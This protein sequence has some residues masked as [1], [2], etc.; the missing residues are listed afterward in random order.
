M[1]EVIKMALYYR[2]RRRKI[3]F[4]IVVPLLILITFLYI[5]LQISPAFI[6]LSED[7]IYSLTFNIINEVIGNELEKIDTT[8]LVDYK[9]DSAGKIVA[10]NA[11]ISIMNKLNNSISQETSKKLDEIETVLVEIPL[12]SFISNSFFSGIGPQLP[13]HIILLNNVTTEY[14]TEFSSTGIN[15]TRHR[16]FITVTC[17]VGALSTLAQNEQDIKVQIP[18][19]ETIIVGNVPTTY[20]DFDNQ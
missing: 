16:I 17:N 20:F 8:S 10:V 15:Q 5:F 4:F 1:K 2:R 13:V 7:K 3:F 9:Y 18:I 14:H 6:K 12:G 11:N 19:A